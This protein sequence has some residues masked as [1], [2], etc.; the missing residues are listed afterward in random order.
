MASTRGP[1]RAAPQAATPASARDSRPPAQ[2]PRPLTSPSIDAGDLLAVDEAA[3]V[4]FHVQRTPDGLRDVVR[5]VPLDGGEGTTLLDDGSFHAVS[6]STTGRVCVDVAARAI[7]PPR[8]T[9]RDADGGE[10]RLL[11]DA[12]TP[13]FLALGLRPPEFLTLPAADGTP[14][15]A[16]RWT[17]EGFGA[18]AKSRPVVVYGYGGPGSRAV[19]DAWQGGHVLVRAL[20]DAGFVVLSVDGRGTGGRGKAFEAVVHRRL[21]ELESDEQ[22]S[23][24]RALA[25]APGIDGAR[26]GIVG[27]PYGGFLPLPAILRRLGVREGIRHP[28]VHAEIE[29]GE[30]EHRRLQA[31]GEVE[32]ADGEVVALLDRRRQ[33]EG[34][35]AVAVRQPRGERDVALRGPRRQAG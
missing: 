23:A 28:G 14:L 13:A 26:V 11:A 31:F 6:F 15:S 3:G 18:T 25:A 12:S 33:E 20:L 22:A 9:V 34:V 2:P 17:P 21:G 4:L 1:P 19:V 7:V 29:V 16:M 8:T 32:R 35:A 10:L 24:V 27:G 5:R 30:H